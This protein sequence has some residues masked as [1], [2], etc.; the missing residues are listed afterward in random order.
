MKIKIKLSPGAI[1]P[2]RADS[3]SAGWDLYAN[4]DVGFMHTDLEYVHTG[5]FLEI[6]PG[7]VGLIFERSS[8]HKRSLALANTVG[9][10]DSSYRG[11]IKLA[12]MKLAPYVRSIKKGDRLCQLVI[13]PV[14]DVEWETVDELDETERA[15]NGFGSSGI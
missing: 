10:I 9:V 3:G 13:V 6:P 5:A 7:Y 14:P 8:L 12:I 2:T 4:D 1:L 11:E 15:A